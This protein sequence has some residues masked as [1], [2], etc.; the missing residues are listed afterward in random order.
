MIRPTVKWNCPIKILKL[1]DARAYSQMVHQSKEEV[2]SMLIQRFSSWDKLR[3][4]L[5]KLT[6]VTS[7]RK[8]RP[9]LDDKGM[10]RVGGRLENAAIDYEA[11]HKISLPY[12]H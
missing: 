7:L 10:L 5:K 4:A 11:K 3:K 12:H 9:M 8:L 2:V 6:A 1:R